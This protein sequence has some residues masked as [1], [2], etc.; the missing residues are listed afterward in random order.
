MMR[1]KKYKRNNGIYH[2]NSIITYEKSEEIRKRG[3]HGWEGVR[4]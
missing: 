1:S 2:K 3:K 4:R